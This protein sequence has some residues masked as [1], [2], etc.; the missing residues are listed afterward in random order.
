MRRIRQQILQAG[1]DYL[2]STN[3]NVQYGT[4]RYHT[5]TRAE[6]RVYAINQLSAILGQYFVHTEDPSHGASW[7]ITEETFIP[8]PLMIYRDP[9]DLAT[10]AV[11]DRGLA[12][13][14]GKCC[15]F[16]S[17]LQAS[18]EDGV[19]NEMYAEDG[20]GL[21]FTLCLDLH[22][23]AEG[24]SALGLPHMLPKSW[25]I[26]PGIGV[27]RSQTDF[28]QV[29]VLHLGHLQGLPKLPVQGFY[30]RHVG[31][32]LHPVEHAREGGQGEASFRRVGVC[33][34]SDQWSN[35]LLEQIEWWDTRMVLV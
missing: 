24:A 32:L 7:Q 27:P 26:A 1:F 3:P 29:V 23:R 14:A 8:D 18:Q 6:D 10:I 28:Q 5:T 2:F 13:A 22:L 25:G 21:D 20:L 35:D 9:V 19:R 4:A 34:W 15:R 17:L 11:G 31:L 12:V 30:R 33:T 16:P